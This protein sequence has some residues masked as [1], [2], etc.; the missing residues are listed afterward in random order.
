MASTVTSALKNAVQEPIL[1]G[2]L[3]YIL[4]RG[5]PHI[6]ERLL[7]PFRTNVLAKNSAAKVASIILVL[8]VLTGV[9]VVRRI[10]QALDKLSW[11]NW[12]L[13]RPGSQFKFGPGKEELVII[14]GGSSGF[15]YEMV[16]GFSKY[17]RIVV[18]D[19]QAFPPELAERKRGLF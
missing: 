8:K 5:P 19:I 2:I 12:T 14:T 17:A 15:G 18:I 4:T 13:G 7:R 16:K 6:R 10:S 11:N 3:L 1:T 9:G